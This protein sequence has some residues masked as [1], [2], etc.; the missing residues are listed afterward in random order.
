MFK[1]VL[2][3]NASALEVAIDK[4]THSRF[5]Y[6]SVPRNLWSAQLCPL[7]LL[8]Y[9]AWALSVDEWDES[10]SED[11]KRK[12]VAASVFVHRHKGTRAAVERAAGSWLPLV[13]SGLRH[14]A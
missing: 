13:S 10:W 11:R 9:L 7:D 3:A 4:L 2:P 6:V 5:D 12:V 14:D 8:P 1:T